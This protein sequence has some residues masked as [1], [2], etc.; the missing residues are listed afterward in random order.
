ML[1]T[2]EEIR[3][4]APSLAPGEVDERSVLEVDV[5]VVGAGLAGSSVAVTLGR[6]G[7]RL[8]LIDRDGVC[9]P[10]F[11]VEKFGG[12]QAQAFERLDLLSGIAASATP[13]SD[14]P[15]IRHG[16]ILDVTREPFHALRYETLVR[17]VREQLPACV[18]F[19]VG[20]VCEVQTGPHRQR[21]ALADNRVIEARL[22]VIATGIGEDLS[23]RL[24][25]SSRVSF[26]KHSVSF[27]FD[28]RSA[29]PEGLRRR[30]LTYY[31][32]GPAT[33]ID[34]LTLF[35][36]GDVVRA[37]LF[38]FVD[39]R[40]PW[41]RDFRRDPKAALLR[42]FPAL[43]SY[44]GEF[45]LCSP[46]QMWVMN[47]HAA[48][49]LERDGVVLLGDAYR[50]SCPAAGIGVARLLTEVERLCRLHVPT[51]LATPGMGRDK[52]AGYYRDPAKTRSDDRAL[53]LSLDRRSLT[54]DR[55]LYWRV[56][57]NEHFLHRD[58]AGRLG[59]MVPA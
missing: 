28:L 37:N 53:K 20:E 32:E 43:P 51:W 44:F 8:A 25:I 16:R 17:A 39:H 36:L 42:S 6:A 10:K 24:G 54:V 2:P 13:F 45:E 50:T 47:L 35:P 1:Q 56:R 34:Y 15:N 41:L 9:P 27:G 59:R 19:V 12:E 33:A 18:S 3:A 55:S 23:E 31:G 29:G 38:T 11:R 7:C 48:E 21:V 14:V 52:I 26:E 58:L 57:R 40:D 4:P 5:A 22:L 46:V 30:A 49:N